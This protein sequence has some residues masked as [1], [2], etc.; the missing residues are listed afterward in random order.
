M[1]IKDNKNIEINNKEV[2]V[3]VAP[4]LGLCCIV[5]QFLQMPQILATIKA[6]IATDARKMGSKIWRSNSNNT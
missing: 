2:E 4:T 6:N 5:E 1:C 3:A